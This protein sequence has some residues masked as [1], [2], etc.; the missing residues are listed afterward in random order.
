MEKTNKKNIDFVL[1]Y[2]EAGKMDTRKA[3]RQIK[4]RTSMKRG[5]HLWRRASIAATLLVLVVAGAMVLFHKGTVTL[6]A[7]NSVKTYLLPDQTKVTL[8]PHAT[9]SYTG[10]NCRQVAMTGKIYFEVKHDEVHPFDITGNL[11]HV[12]VLGTK[13]MV[14]ERAA[15]AAVYVTSGR[16]MFAGKGETEGMILTRGMSATLKK[17]MK[18]PRQDADGDINATAWA[19][20]TFHFDGTPI[21]DVLNTLS[22]YY[23]VRLTTDDTGKRLSGDF[24]AS[25]INDLTS[26]IE[27][28]LDIKISR[29]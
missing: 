15:A 10:D 4:E 26:I 9:L 13:F 17:G 12:R 6:T 22:D 25:D 27:E 16:V 19:T 14:D 21:D 23:G 29:K 28:T 20:H 3:L 2:Y 5:L 18:K 11:S 7:A 24:D 1:R 8:A